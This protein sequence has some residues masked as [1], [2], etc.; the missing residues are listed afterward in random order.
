MSSRDAILSRV[1]QSLRVD[2]ADSERRAIVSARLEG[3]PRGVVPKRGQLPQP[4]RV[5]LFCEM[6]EKVSAT[7]ARITGG[8]AVPEAVII[9]SDCKSAA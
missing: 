7:V 8:V 5:A 2:A 9:N 4:E 3:T 1:R 6:A